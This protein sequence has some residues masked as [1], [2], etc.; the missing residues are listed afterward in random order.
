MARTAACRSSW[1]CVWRGTR[2]G[3][4]L[5]ARLRSCRGPCC[6][7]RRARRRRGSRRSRTSRRRS[8]SPEARCRQRRA[9]DPRDSR[10]EQVLLDLGRR[11][12]LLAPAGDVEDVGVSVG[13]RERGGGLTCERD[14]RVF[15]GVDGE[16]DAEG[17]AAQRERCE[18][19]AGKLLRDLRTQLV[20]AFAR[21]FRPDGERRARAR[22]TLRSRPV[23]RDCEPSRS[24]RYNATEVTPASRRASETIWSPSRC[25]G[26]LLSTSVTSSGVGPA[27]ELARRAGARRG[28]W[29]PRCPPRS[30][31][32]RARARRATRSGGRRSR[33]RRGRRPRSPRGWPRARSLSSVIVLCNTDRVW[34]RQLSPRGIRRREQ[35]MRV[36]S[37]PC[38]DD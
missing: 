28:R 7:Q 29:H 15:G 35:S 19:A 37:P 3:R 23:A 4:P 13:Q 1:P 11:A 12:G 22:G 38:G 8:R 32:R 31:W 34:S 16:H 17:P 27:G 30:G 25:G 26:T 33:V 20:Q 24:I 6:R 5:R 36:V 10:R 2:R 9:G 18:G 14:Q 21:Q